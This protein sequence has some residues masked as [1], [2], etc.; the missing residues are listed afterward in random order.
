MGGHRNDLLPPS[1]NESMDDILSTSTTNDSDKSM[2]DIPSTPATSNELQDSDNINNVGTMEAL[3]VE[4]ESA[5]LRDPPTD[6]NSDQTM[7][8][9]KHTPTEQI[10]DSENVESTNTSGAEDFVSAHEVNDAE[11]GTLHCGLEQPIIHF[12]HASSIKIENSEIV[13]TIDEEEAAPP[14]ED[15]ANASENATDSTADSAADGSQVESIDPNDAEEIVSHEKKD[16]IPEVPSSSIDAGGS[17][18]DADSVGADEE[19]DDAVMKEVSVVVHVC[20]NT[21]AY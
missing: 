20:V 15:I 8:N 1:G 2:E 19:D 18:D 5:N 9:H 4:D 11:E 21:V 16:H 14:V 12:D 13:H 6:S 7:D 3:K 17:E 10:V